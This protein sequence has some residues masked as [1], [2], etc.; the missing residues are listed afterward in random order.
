MARHRDHAPYLRLPLR[1]DTDRPSYSARLH[2]QQRVIED[3]RDI[4]H[5]QQ[6]ALTAGGANF[7]GLPAGDRHE[8][9]LPRSWRVQR[10]ADRS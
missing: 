1:S 4:S 6:P 7:S 8:G 3:E 2:D 5:H 9:G 10:I